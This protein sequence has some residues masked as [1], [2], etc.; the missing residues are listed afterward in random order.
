MHNP[1]CIVSDD[2]IIASEISDYTFIE[3]DG[4]KLV[5]KKKGHS[6]VKQATLHSEICAGLS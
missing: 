4:S 6:V 1:G 5:L 3:Q 2:L